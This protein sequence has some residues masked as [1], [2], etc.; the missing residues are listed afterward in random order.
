MRAHRKVDWLV[1]VAR[2]MPRP[3]NCGASVRRVRAQASSSGVDW[4]AGGW[5][6]VAECDGVEVEDEDVVGDG[7]GEED[8]GGCMAWRW[9]VE[10]QAQSEMRRPAVWREFF[11]LPVSW[12]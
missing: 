10:A 7:G 5:G 9:V 8:G 11:S 6:S 12:R 2:R 4:L 1:W 3:A